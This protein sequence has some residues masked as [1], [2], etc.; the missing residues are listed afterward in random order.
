MHDIVFQ[1]EKCVGKIVGN[2]VPKKFFE[3]E[4][5]DFG[6]DVDAALLADEGFELG[7]VSS[8]VSLLIH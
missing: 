1:V 3:E 8:L 7:V 2:V 4:G 6:E 5:F